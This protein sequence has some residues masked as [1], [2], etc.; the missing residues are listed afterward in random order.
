MIKMWMNR[1]YRLNNLLRT[2]SSKLNPAKGDNKA[3]INEIKP[4]NIVGRFYQA[5]LFKGRKV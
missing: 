5:L 2:F 3:S 1:N 4:E